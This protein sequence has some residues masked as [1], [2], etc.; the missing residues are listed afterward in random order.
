MK[1][2][3]DNRCIKIVSEI[4]QIDLAELEAFVLS[5]PHGNFFQSTKAFQFYQAVN[6]N[7]PI[8]L[9]AKDG[10]KIVGSLLAV[11]IREGKGPK[12][13]FSRRCIVSGGPLGV[14]D[15]V[16]I[17]ADLLSALNEK[18]RNKA[19]YT[20]FRNFYD[21]SLLNNAF[22]QQGWLYEEHLNIL[23]DLTKPESD[24]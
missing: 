17:C 18:V 9:V 8:L 23:I 2:R 20:Q 12:G 15:D 11:I 24:L 16:K 21:M 22:T 3:V 13:F 5:H 6:N 19:I 4:A 10:E 1:G 7:Q 14:E